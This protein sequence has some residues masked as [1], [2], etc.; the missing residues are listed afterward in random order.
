[1]SQIELKNISKV[2]KEKGFETKA[3]ENIQLKV[4]KGE[5]LGIMGPS[6]SGKS[7]LLN[8]LGCIDTPTNGQYLLN[9]KDIASYSLKEK[10]KIRNSQFGFILQDFALMERHRVDQNI[11]LP[12]IY[13]KKSKKQRSETVRELLDLLGIADK[14]KVYPTMLSGGQRQRVAIARA[15]AM[16]AEIILSD[17]PTGALDS[18]NSMAL[19]DIFHR[20]NETGKTIIIVTHDQAIAQH[21]SQ[22]L[23]MNDGVLY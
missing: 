6:G 15:L 21:C 17:E 22:I 19:M 16:D 20:I 13:A 11:E 2:Y 12:M 9:D 3:L 5:M 8:I 14:G 10:A 23:T 1:M 7:T 18:K 4:E